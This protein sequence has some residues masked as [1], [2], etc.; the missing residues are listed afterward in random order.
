MH[1]EIDKLKE[2]VKKLQKKTLT[3]NF[4][5]DQ[6]KAQKILQKITHITD[7][8]KDFK[9]MKAQSE[10][11]GA[12]IELYEESGE[13]E[14]EDDIKREVCDLRKSL[15]QARLETLF[16]GKYDHRNVIL[17]LHAGAGGTEAQDW[18]SMLLRMYT[19]WAEGKGYSVKTL[20]LLTGDE[21]GVKSVTLLVKGH[22]AYGYL[23]SE[24]G[25]HRLVRISPF[26]SAKRRHTSFASV[27]I[28]PEIEDDIEIDIKPSE[29]KIDTFRAGGAGGQHVNK[30]DSAVRITHLPTNIVVSCQNE[31]SQKSNKDTAMKVLKSKLLDL[32]EQQ[33]QEE[34]DKIRGNQ[35]QIA[36][37]NQIRS[38]IFHPYTM[39]KD[40]RTNLEIGNIEAVM[41]GKIDDFINEYLKMQTR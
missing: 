6:E 2:E 41:D 16:K 24:K 27:D 28:L 17:S 9:E 18:A 37:G 36:W 1:F 33:Q 15:K 31:R 20:D 40:H 4:W 32:Y 5:D 11:L 30:T 8:I 29:L 34:I 26:D 19:R 10:D 3:Q 13:V 25:V 7:K 35:S 38:Y 21:A 39:V 23:K 22:N 14:L 12:L